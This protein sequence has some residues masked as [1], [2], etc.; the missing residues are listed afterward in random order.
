MRSEVKVS[1]AARIRISGKRR[2][3]KRGPLLVTDDGNVWLL[4]MADSL[5]LPSFGKIT[6]EGTQSGFDR[7]NVDWV[8]TEL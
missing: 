7:L 6:V 1:K 5:L 4:E 8:N 2:N 3:S